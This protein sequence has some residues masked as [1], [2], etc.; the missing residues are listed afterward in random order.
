MLVAAAHSFSIDVNSPWVVL[1]TVCAAAVTVTAFPPFR[2]SALWLWR[3]NVAEP[4]AAWFQGLVRDE[5]TAVIKQ[6]LKERNGGASIPDLSDQLEDLGNRLIELG[7]F[8]HDEVKYT[9]N[10][11]HRLNGQVGMMWRSYAIE[12]GVDPKDLPPPA[13]SPKEGLE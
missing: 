11:V 12:H 10:E 1:L 5:S 4:G 9:H 6:E 3:R 7:T 13:P 2:R 8:T